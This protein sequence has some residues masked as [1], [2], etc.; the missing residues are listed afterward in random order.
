MNPTT[1]VC[2]LW[3]S[4]GDAFHDF[5]QVHRILAQGAELMSIF[6]GF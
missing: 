4:F 6:I 2:I 1:Q 5:W 3:S